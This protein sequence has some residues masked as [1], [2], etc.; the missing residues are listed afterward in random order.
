MRY[1]LSVKGRLSFELEDEPYRGRVDGSDIYVDID[2]IRVPDYV[3]IT[4]LHGRPEMRY[5]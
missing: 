3:I 4:R 5:G 2:P 1:S